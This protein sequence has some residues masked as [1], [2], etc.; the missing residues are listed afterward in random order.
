[1]IHLFVFGTEI[2]ICQISA[3]GWLVVGGMGGVNCEANHEPHIFSS[4]S[5]KKGTFHF[6][7]SDKIHIK[8]NFLKKRNKM[9]KFGK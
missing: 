4:I 8:R 9:A 3:L 6:H 1:M 2:L 7:F 5:D